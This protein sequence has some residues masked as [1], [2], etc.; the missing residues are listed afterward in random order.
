MP[1]ILESFGSGIVA[2]VFGSGGGIGAALTRALR[3][4]P[5]VDHVFACSRTAPDSDDRVTGL[6]FDLCDEESIRNAVE[7][8]ERKSPFHAVFVATGIL[9]NSGT[10]PEKR[11]KDLSAETLG[12]VFAVNTTGPAL[13]AKHALDGL[14]RGRKSVFCA[15]SARV[16]SIED[17]RLGG[18]HAYRASK[19]ALNMILRS[20]S[21]ELAHKNPDAIC[22]AVHPGTVDTRLS[23]PFQRGVPEGQLFSPALAAEQILHV[24]DGLAPEDSGGFF[25]WD[26]TRIAF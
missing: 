20:C 15:L 16:G 14:A 11:W 7:A 13:I 22:V 2:S 9:Q 5:N 18:W 3:D 21:V 23:R 8:M 4:S 6:A 19:A 25:A 1:D 17:N 24:V 12:N 10:G 26:G